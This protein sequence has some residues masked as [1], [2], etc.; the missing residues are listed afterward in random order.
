MGRFAVMIGRIPISNVAPVVECGRWPAKAAVGEHITISATVFREGHDAVAANAVLV[1]PD[2]REQPF[3]RMRA[4]GGGTDDWRTQALVD[5]EGEW[6]FR[7]GAGGASPR[8]GGGHPSPTGRQGAKTK[9]PLA[10][11]AILV[12]GGGPRLHERAAKT[13]P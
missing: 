4:L 5:T 10:Q 2:G 3:N 1:S 7:I 11:A 12:G 6:T 8:W 13:A 9:A